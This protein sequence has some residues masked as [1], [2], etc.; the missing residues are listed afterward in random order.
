MINRYMWSHLDFL[1]H[2]DISKH[3][4]Y[5]EVTSEI[6]KRSLNH[7]KLAQLRIANAEN[8]ELGEVVRDPK[9]CDPMFSLCG[10]KLITIIY[11]YIRNALG[12][13]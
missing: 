4:E 13:L 5:R 6:L 8:Y 9:K 10:G 3:V 12:T 1:Y 7:V 2:A 11:S